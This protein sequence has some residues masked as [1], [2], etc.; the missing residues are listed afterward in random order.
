MGGHFSPL[1]LIPVMSVGLQRSGTMRG[2]CLRAVLPGTLSVKVRRKKRFPQYEL[3]LLKEK[4]AAACGRTV[5]SP[6]FRLETKELITHPTNAVCSS[7][8]RRGREAR[9]FSLWGDLESTEIPRLDDSH[10]RE[11]RPSLLPM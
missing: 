4:H 8:W 2:T 7:G 5:D 10:G 1:R 9:R 6:Q 11:E 3:S